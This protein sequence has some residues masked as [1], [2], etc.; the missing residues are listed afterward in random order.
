MRQATVTP[1]GFERGIAIVFAAVAVLGALVVMLNTVLYA[2]GSD[3]G[4]VP[5]P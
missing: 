1:D 2:I 5:L 3:G 4:G